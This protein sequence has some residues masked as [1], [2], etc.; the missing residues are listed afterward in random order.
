MT[1]YTCIVNEVGPASDG[2]ETPA[3]VVYI[4]LTDKA[5]SFSDTWF[6]AA[7]GVQQQVLD[8]G[9]GAIKANREV[10]VGAVAPVAGNQP[11]TEISRIY[12][13]P[14]PPAAP[15][16]FHE[17]SQ[18][19]LGGDD[20]LTSVEVAWKANSYNVDSFV[21]SY[22]GTQSG[23]PNNDGEVS[24]GGNI[25]SVNLAL[26]DGY[27][28]DIYVTAVNSLGDARSGTITVTIPPLGTGGGTAVLTVGVGPLPQNL[29][30]SGL[31]IEGNDFGASET[32]EVTV[33]WQVTGEVATPFPLVTQTNSFGY[34]VVWF[35][36]SDPDGLCPITVADGQPQPRQYFSVSATGLTSHKTAS[37]TAG[38]FICPED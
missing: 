4:N 15:S 19:P 5:G 9:I 7:N 26:K 13:F 10:E 3:P 17:V 27:I 31:R 12:G 32:V 35:S 23:K 24:V 21:V 22:N 38:P 25:T 1:W 14:L 11:Y 2:T 29:S 33:D 6:Y 28:Y 18:S 30:N 8:V 34:F 37:A 20:D 16:D 36:G